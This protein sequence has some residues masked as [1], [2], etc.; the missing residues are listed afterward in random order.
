MAYTVKMP[1]ETVT[2]LHI[3]G[4]IKVILWITMFALEREC[5]LT[6]GR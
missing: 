5:M 3:G 2:I 6:G 4:Y 1:F